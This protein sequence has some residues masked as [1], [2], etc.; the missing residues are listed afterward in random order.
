MTLPHSPGLL[1]RKTSEVVVAIGG[2]GAL[3]RTSFFLASPVFIPVLLAWSL[4]SIFCIPH[5]SSWT[6]NLSW[7][8]PLRNPLSLEM[9]TSTEITGG[10]WLRC[11]GGSGEGEKETHAL[12]VCVVLSPSSGPLPLLWSGTWSSSPR[13]CEKECSFLILWQPM[14]DKEKISLPFATLRSN[15]LALCIC[16]C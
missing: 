5:I 16:P 12:L 10:K 13:Y 6:S 2:G 4:F 15:N 11:T 14:W 8:S 3:Q 9:S 7:F 1:R